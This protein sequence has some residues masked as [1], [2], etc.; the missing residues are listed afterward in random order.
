MNN[1]WESWLLFYEIEG[2]KIYH[3]HL[4][5]YSEIPDE[6]AINSGIDELKNDPVFGIGDK[7]FD[8]EYRILEKEEGALL[9]E[10]LTGVENYEQVTH[11]DK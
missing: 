2:D 11:Y 5:G 7:I 10:F 8:L 3:H 6:K 9:S 4:I 1:E